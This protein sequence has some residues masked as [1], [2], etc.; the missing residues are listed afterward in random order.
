MIVVFIIAKI[1][2]RK[3]T[4]QSI[5]KSLRDISKNTTH[6]QIEPMKRINDLRD[7]DRLVFFYKN[8]ISIDLR[9][10]KI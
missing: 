1:R 8:L 10:M 7:D 5:P 3:R 6:Q 9:P 4:V 2:A